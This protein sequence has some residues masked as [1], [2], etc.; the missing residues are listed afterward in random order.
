MR[1][2]AARL[3]RIRRALR[4]RMRERFLTD[5]RAAL[6]DIGLRLQD[7]A[8][9]DT[10]AYVR[11]RM[12]LVQPVGS[13]REVHDIAIAQAP[14]DGMVLE[15]GVFSGATVNHLAA[16]TGWRIDAFDSFQGLPEAWRGGYPKG[17]FARNTLPKVAPN[18]SLHVGWFAE[19][20]PR[21]LST[22]GRDRVR[23]LHIDSDLYS[24]ARTIFDHLGERIRPRTVIVFDEYFN[25][26]G[27]RQGEYRAFQEFVA[28][29]GLRYEYLT[30]NH[31]HQ[32]V[33]VRI[34]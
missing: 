7:L 2:L 28:R 25:Y 1:F 20:L 31:R 27:W 11:D 17:T 21:F 32:Q 34:A 5:Y 13:W 8:T 16:R 30:Y 23:Y 29:T 4:Q 22:D 9:L 10:A 18:V 33:A 6:S 15:F 12:P 24:S 14:R 3:T 26:D 19:S